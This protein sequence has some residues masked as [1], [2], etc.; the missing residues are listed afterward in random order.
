MSKRAHT[1]ETHRGHRTAWLR[2]GVLGADDGIV[3][4]AALMVGTATAHSSD[5]AVL[6]AGIAGLVAGA[7]SM[8][9]G[10]YVSVSSQRDT[11]V[12]DRDK[13]LNELEQYPDAELHELTEIYM[14]RGLDADLA[15]QVAIQMHEHDALAAHLRDELGMANGA[16]ARPVQAAA[17]SAGSFAFGALLPW[18]TALAGGGAGAIS[19]V[20]MVALAVL[21]WF[22]ASLG[23]A[24]PWRGA[25]R[26][27]VGGGVALGV[28]AL[29][30]SLVGNAGL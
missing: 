30:G 25:L 2:A 7:L 9:A 11:E 21:G 23:G 28:T 27:L 14:Q 6:T 3:S 15:R 26:V 22:G 8:A 18:L 20:A 4:T 24:P 5:S 1:V 16:E 12:A 29:V 10:E 17:V 19:L 13:E